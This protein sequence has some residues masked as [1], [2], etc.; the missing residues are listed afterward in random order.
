[1]KALKYHLIC[2][3]ILLQ[4][5]ASYNNLPAAKIINRARSPTEIYQIQRISPKEMGIARQMVLDLPGEI[6]NLIFH[7]P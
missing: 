1:M 7:D 5:I 4:S 3:K 2:N 6:Q